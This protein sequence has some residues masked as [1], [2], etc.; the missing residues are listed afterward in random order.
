MSTIK[1]NGLIISQKGYFTRPNKLLRINCQI[2]H[3]AHVERCNFVICFIRTGHC[4]FRGTVFK[5]INLDITIYY[6]FII[7]IRLK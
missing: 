7:G 1:L 6:F 2:K 5:E 3:M 4:D